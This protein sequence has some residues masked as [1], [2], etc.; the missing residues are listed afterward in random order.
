LK[1]DF[2]YVGD[3]YRDIEAAKAANVKIISV[4]WGFN[5]REVLENANSGYIAEDT[6]EI[7]KLLA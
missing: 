1:S 6:E 2:I 7:L 5:S 4:T 3:E